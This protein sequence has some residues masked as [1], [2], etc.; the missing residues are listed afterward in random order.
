[1]KKWAIDLGFITLDANRFCAN[2]ELIVA[3]PP[4]RPEWRDRLFGGSSGERVFW[5]VPPQTPIC[6]KP[7]GVKYN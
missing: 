4:R 1:M 5:G 6:T 7:N 3:A 2:Q